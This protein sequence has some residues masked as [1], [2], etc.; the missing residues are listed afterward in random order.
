MFKSQPLLPTSH[1]DDTKPVMTKSS[2][3][4][5]TSFNVSA[6]KE[7]PKLSTGNIV[8]WK[9]GIKIHLK[10]AGLY[11]FIK[12]S[13]SRP[14]TAPECSHFD[15]RQAAVLHL[16]GATVDKSNKAIIDSLDDPKEAY[17][18]LVSQHGN[19]DGFT[20]ANTLTELF[21]T[22]YDPSTSMHDYLA[23]IQDLHSRVRDL[24]SGDPELK[25]SD[26]LFLIVLINSLPRTTYATV[27]QQLLSNIKTITMAQVSAQ[28][29]LEAV[30]MATDEE[31]FKGVYAAKITKPNNRKVGSKTQQPKSGIKAQRSVQHSCQSKTHKLSVFHS[32]GE[33]ETQAL[34][35]IE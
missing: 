13:Q 31:K 10:M 17:D 35:F 23:K 14:D 15:M 24:T 34:R 26:K 4:S 22:K 18:V 21:S 33:V 19:D 3:Q 8:S 27:I 28:L 6:L 9:Q 7:I 2:G 11:H 30:S 32:E 5:M 20:T 25:I 12:H 16:I 29:R 1:L